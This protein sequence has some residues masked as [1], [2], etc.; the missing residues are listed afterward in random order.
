[1]LTS[2]IS[3]SGAERKLAREIAAPGE[4][5]E[6][7]VRRRWRRRSRDPS[8]Y[9]RA[10]AGEIKNFTASTSLRSQRRPSLTL[11][12]VDVVGRGARRPRHREL[13]AR[14]GSIGFR[15]PSVAAAAFRAHLR[16]GR[17]G[18]DGGQRLRGAARARG[19]EALF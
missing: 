12:G 18:R 2:F 16:R 13:E 11:D 6:I 17:N 3:P 9:K 10:L 8:L 14:G 7:Y 19:P 5:I 1:V 4:F 15:R